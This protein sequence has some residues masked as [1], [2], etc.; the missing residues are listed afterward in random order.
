MK[1]LILELKREGKT[2]L[3]NSH[4]LN[5]VEKVADRAIILKE[6]IKLAEV[7]LQEKN[8]AMNLEEIFINAVGGMKN[9]D[10]H[11]EYL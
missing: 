11:D 8:E 1:N 6:G 10:H 7:N 4:I 3:L 9:A 2:I 5:D